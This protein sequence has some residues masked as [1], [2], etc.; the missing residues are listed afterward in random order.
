MKCFQEIRKEKLQEIINRHEEFDFSEFLVMLRS[1][2]GLTQKC[3]SREIGIPEWTLHRLETARIIRPPRYEH[4][5]MLADYYG[6]SHRLL[7]QKA[8]EFVRAKKCA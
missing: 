5:V 4:I 8:Q 2:I 7:K 6:I 3:L 1:M